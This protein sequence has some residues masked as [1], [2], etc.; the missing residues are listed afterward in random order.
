MAICFL[1]DSLV[2]LIIW[3]SLK[4]KSTRL[5]QGSKL[6]LSV[7]TELFQIASNSPK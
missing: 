2:T 3:I 5:Y 6:T 4:V 1:A 7:L